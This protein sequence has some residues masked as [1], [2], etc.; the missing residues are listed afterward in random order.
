MIL[1]G[2]YGSPFVRRV[3]I[4]MKLLGVEFAVKALSA[5]QNRAEVESLNPLGRVPALVLED[6]EVLVDSGAILD[7][8]DE[9]V[10]PQRALVPVSGAP[11]RQVLRAVALAVGSMEKTVAC[12]VEKTVRPEDKR[13]PPFLER[14][15]QQALAGLTALEA[16]AGEP[17]W[18]CGKGLTQADVSAV[19]ALDFLHV[20]RPDLL[21]D[22]PLPR[23]ES[24]RARTSALPAFAETRP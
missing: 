4:S 24:L 14:F 15:G 12:F 19:V 20:I 7:Y 6:G 3:A 21:L 8:L 17:D 1:I 18:L 10:G 2:R 22:H 13:H 11:R 9:L 5:A 23:L 16:M